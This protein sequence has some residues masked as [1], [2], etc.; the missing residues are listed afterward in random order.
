MLISNIQKVILSH[1]L[2][3]I[4]RLEKHNVIISYNKVCINLDNF[5][6]LIV[7]LSFYSNL[8]SLV[9]HERQMSNELCWSHILILSSFGPILVTC[10]NFHPFFL[11]FFLWIWSATSKGIWIVPCFLL[12]VML[13]VIVWYNGFYHLN[14]IILNNLSQIFCTSN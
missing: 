12:S 14:R 4:H 13:L 3:I 11:F 8:M 10:H 5:E 9:E 2:F 6:F 7:F 1:R